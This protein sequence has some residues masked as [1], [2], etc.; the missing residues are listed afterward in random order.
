MSVYSLMSTSSLLHYSIKFPHIFVSQ[1][2]KLKLRLK[3]VPQIPS[4]Q[5]SKIGVFTLRWLIIQ[6]PSMLTT[7]QHSS[8]RLVR[9]LVKLNSHSANVLI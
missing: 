3:D 4:F 6:D 2:H 9:R 8:V 1:F 7:H 5:N